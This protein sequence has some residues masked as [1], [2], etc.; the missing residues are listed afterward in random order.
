MSHFISI[1]QARKMT[2]ALRKSGELI[3][4]PVHKG[5]NIIPTSETFDRE[6]FDALLSQPDCTSIRIYYGMDDKLKV[7]ALAVGVNSKNEDILPLSERGVEAAIIVENGQRCPT[8]C[9]PSSSINP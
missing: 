5:L 3:L 8:A 1:E 7:H 4:N 2:A 6:A 9:P